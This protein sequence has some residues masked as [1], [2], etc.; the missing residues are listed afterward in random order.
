M[1]AAGRGMEH[2]DIT[3]RG[4]GAQPVYGTRHKCVECVD[5]DLCQACLSSPMVRS[6]HDA[7]HHLSPIECPWDHAAFRVVS[8]RL[9]PPANNTEHRTKC[10]GCQADNLAGVR[11]RCLVCK[12]FNFCSSC[13]MDP[14]KRGGHDLKHVFFPIPYPFLKY[15]WFDK[16]ADHPAY[17]AARSRYRARAAIEAGASSAAVFP[18]ALREDVPILA[19]AKTSLTSL[20]LDDTFQG[21]DASRPI[22]RCCSGCNRRDPQVCHVCVECPDV[23]LCDICVSLVRIRSRHNP[24]HH[25]TLLL[26]GCDSE[27]RKRTATPLSEDSDCSGCLMTLR[28]MRHQCLVCTNYAICI[29]CSRD[30]VIFADHDIS[31][32]F[33]P[34]SSSGELSR[35]KQA[36][37]RHL[38]KPSGELKDLLKQLIEHSPDSDGM[39]DSK[40]STVSSARYFFTL[41]GSPFCISRD[42]VPWRSP[43]YPDILIP[44]LT[45]FYSFHSRS[46]GDADRASVWGRAQMATTGVPDEEILFRSAGPGECFTLRPSP[47]SSVPLQW[48]HVGPGAIPDDLADIPC[49]DLSVDTLLH[50]LNSVMGTVHKLDAPGLRELLTDTCAI[51]QDFG[52]V[53]GRLRTWWNVSRDFNQIRAVLEK[54]QTRDNEIRRDIIRGSSIE[55]ARLPPRRVWD[56]FSNRVIPFHTR[57]PMAAK[58]SPRRSHIHIPGRLWTVSHSW[59]DDR[60]RGTIYTNIN[61]NQWPVPVPSADSFTLGHVRVELLNMGAEYV[62]LDALCLRQRGDPKDELVR[63]EEWGLDVPTIGS[64]YNATRQLHCIVYFNGLGLPLDTRSS[65][66][67]SQRHWFNRVWTLQ[68]TLSTWIPGG[69]PGDALADCTSVFTRMDELTGPNFNARYRQAQAL[70]DRSCTTELDRIAG[71]AYIFHC[72]TLPLYKED[73]P[74]ERAW[75]L[76]LKHMDSR[77]R[78]TIFLHYAVDEPFA[79]CITWKQYILSDPTLPQPRVAFVPY[80]ELQLA[81]PPELYTN[82]PARFCHLAHAVGPCHIRR[83]RQDTSADSVTELE[84]LFENE[85]AP[86]AFEATGIHGLLLEDVAYTMLGIGSEAFYDMDD[87]SFWKEYWIVVETVGERSILAPKE[88]RDDERTR[89]IV[90]FEAIKWAVIRVE[91]DTGIELEEL[92]IGRPKTPVVYI[93]G[94]EARCRSSHTKEYMEAFER[95]RNDGKTVY[96]Q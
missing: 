25:F 56:L 21:G 36:A 42:T 54:A 26:P 89:N 60:E 10:G 15:K 16:L 92:E 81:H 17:I 71:L 49:A 94:E 37:R 59:V 4:C 41:E 82:D 62:W 51:S 83:L 91:K 50:K 80:E 78:T 23:A 84:L 74:V 93:D 69:L 52:E 2:R 58:T 11:H 33:F 35:I 12:H 34:L 20:E 85:G 61:G 53:Y 64:V 43:L 63:K 46:D 29:A 86:F 24:S 13:F 3:C 6:Q 45:E 65:T 47:R 28:G 27:A 32:P 18:V 66:L 72:D 30:P 88:L 44:R 75:T 95:M 73:T 90:A 79:L 87:D 31:H 8:L 22:L 76:L 5:Y 96:I 55:H 39:P 19:Q 40:S 38:R 77:F 57:Y 68:E 14:R 1:Q 70:K 9:V 67:S 48:V 7:T